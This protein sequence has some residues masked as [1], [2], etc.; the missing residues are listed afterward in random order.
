MLSALV[1]LA[2]VALSAVSVR[3]DNY[4]VLVAG[5][6]TYGNYRH[7][8]DVCHAYKLLRKYGIP[9]SN[10]IT[11]MFD[12]VAF[13]EMNP[14]PG[15]LFNRPTNNHTRGVD[16]YVGCGGSIEANIYRGADVIPDVYMAVITGNV[17]GVPAGKAV[18]KSTATDDVF[19]N[20][21]D[22]GGPGTV[23]YTSAQRRTQQE[24]ARRRLLSLFV[25][26]MSLTCRVVH[27]VVGCG[28][29]WLW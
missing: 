18:L 12:D 11:F 24:P 13:D 29:C 8:A 19:L 10:I 3:A 22:H 4:A 17:S 6:N 21:V 26:P 15:R 23:S 2:V 28:W 16:V 7:Q 25:A 14:F 27:A 1:L 5:S 20:F 9:E